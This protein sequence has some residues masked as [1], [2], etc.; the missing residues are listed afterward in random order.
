M[1][2]SDTAPTWPAANVP[3]GIWDSGRVR[4]AVWPA[5]TPGAAP[6]DAVPGGRVGNDAGGDA[7]V[8]GI[9][10]VVDGRMVRAATAREAA[11]ANQEPIQLLPV[12]SR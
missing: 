3:K 11:S 12:A 10:V 6:A 2:K 5:G 1:N 9:V 7:V 8:S 4:R